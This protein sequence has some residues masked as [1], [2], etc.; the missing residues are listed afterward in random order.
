M[1]G[2]KDRCETMETFA[3]TA[4]RA[5]Q[6]LVNSMAAQEPDWVLFSFDISQA[7]AKGMDFAEMARHTGTPLRAVEFDLHSLDIPVL[8]K[9]KGFEDFD[10]KSE[11]LRMIKPIYGLKDASR[12]W[13]HKLHQVLSDFGLQQLVA[14]GEVYVLHDT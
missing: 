8:R 4:S 10:P 14:E 11:T 13:R 9:L 7:F 5:G 3:G 12:A 1:R 6:R 2:F